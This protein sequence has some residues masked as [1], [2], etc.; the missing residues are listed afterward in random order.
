[1]NFTVKC[2]DMAEETVVVFDPSRQIVKEGENK[3]PY[4]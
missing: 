3:I 4:F 2:D 1:M